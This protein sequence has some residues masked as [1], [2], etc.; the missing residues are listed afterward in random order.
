[1]QI[2]AALES[3]APAIAAIYAPI[4]ESSAISFETEPPDA[5]EMAARIRATVE[6]Y[7]WLVL[8]TGGQIQGYAYASALRTRVAYRWSA[9]T[10]IYVHAEHRRSGAGRALYCALLRTLAVQGFV[11]AYGAITLPNPASVRFHEALDFA[12]V[13]VFPGVGYKLGA[14]H[15]V[16]FYR[17]VLAPCPE[18]PEPP[19]PFA[20][21]RDQTEVRA[22]IAARS[23]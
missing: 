7:P 13:G 5:L 20:R 19:R 10:T 6:I 8:E 3:D 11:A 12:C 17:R 16:G 14:W 23:C 2:R 21:V 9:E 4:V 18:R 15:D 1:M 22:T